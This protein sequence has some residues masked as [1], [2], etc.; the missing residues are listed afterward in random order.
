MDLLTR[1][2][3]KCP[4]IAALSLY[5]R[6]LIRFQQLPKHFKELP[7]VSINYGTI[8]YLELLLS[9]LSL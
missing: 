4:E 9:Q 2:T 7:E 1:K 8:K 5:L 3:F 6:F